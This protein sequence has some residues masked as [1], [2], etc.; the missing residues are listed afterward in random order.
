MIYKDEL[1]K[2]MKL[3]AQDSRVIFLGQNIIYGGNAIFDTL[4]GVPFNKRIELPVAEEMQLGVSIGLSLEGFL[5]V[6]IFPRMDFLVLAVNQLVNHL[7]KVEE[8][9]HGEFKAKVIIRTMIGSTKPLNPGPQHTG[10]Y[11]DAL[12][13]MLKN[14][15]VIKLTRAEDIVP[16]YKKALESGKSTVLVEIGDLYN[17]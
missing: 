17:V 13:L 1:K 8:M 3:L 15:D 6:S 2:T 5:P 16:A 7:D 11:T 12:R 14:I 10:D 4:E 9:S